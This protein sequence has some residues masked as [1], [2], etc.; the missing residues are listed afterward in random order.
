M[1]KVTLLGIDLAKNVFQLHGVNESGEVVLKKQIRNRIHFAR[2]IAKLSQC[3]IGMEACGSAHYWARRFRAMGHQ[4]KL[5]HPKYVKAFVDRNKND[6]ADAKACY[7]ALCQADMPSVPIK[8]TDQQALLMLEKSR[9]LLLKQRGQ[10]NNQLRAGLYEFGLA[11]PRGKGSLKLKVIELLEDAGNELPPL[12]RE[13]IYDQLIEYKALSKRIEA[14]TKRIELIAKE[15]EVCRRLQAIPGIGPITAFML[16]ASLQ[17][18]SFEKGRQAAAWIGLTPKEYSSGGTRRLLGISK[19]GNR[20]L[21][22]LLIHG[23]RAVV[24]V[25]DKKQD[26]LSLWIQR[27]KEEQGF[28]KAVVALANKTARQA[29][30][31]ILNKTNYQTDFADYYKLAA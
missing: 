28:N 14:Y 1:S 7:R 3:Q 12:A 22:C 2:F 19:Q 18:Y 4:V 5:M 16:T 11:L 24:S 26:R 20:R 15:D 27:I 6:A 8:S 10:L 21:R 29:W 31:M 13:L 17:G 30:S 23:A 9:A 25:A